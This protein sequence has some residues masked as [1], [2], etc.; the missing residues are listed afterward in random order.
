MNFVYPYFLWAAFA[1]AI[2]ILIHLFNFR[3][4]KKVYFTNVT[5]LRQAQISTRKQNKLKNLLLLL[6][7]CL[8][9]VFLAFLFAQPYVENK[10]NAIVK[11]SGNA[12][13]VFVDNSFSMENAGQSGRLLDDAKAKARQIVEQFNQNDN[14]L[15]LTMDME[16]RHKHFVDKEQF[17]ASLN[18]VDITAATLK[19][20][21]VLNECNAMLQMRNEEKRL[22]VVSDFQTSSFD[23]AAFENDSTAKTFLLPVSANNLN[24][25]FVDS[26]WFASDFLHKGQNIDI[27]A[28]I[29][30]WDEESVEKIPVKLFINEKQ[31]AITSIDLDS[32]RSQNVTMSFV[33]D[34]NIGTTL[35]HGK[36]SI[37]DSPVTFDD[38][39]YFAFNV[40]DKISVCIING[41]QNNKYLE[42]LFASAE[43]VSLTQFTEN[44]I[45]YN[46]LPKFSTII[47]NGV[48]QITSGLTDEMKRFCEDGGTIIIIPNE[49]IDIA[50]YQK[51]MHDLQ[52]ATY[53]RLMTK[54][55]KVSVVN[56]ESSLY[57]G[58]FGS[59]SKG[60]MPI[61]DNMEMPNVS[62][63]FSFERNNV[64]KE[65]IMKFQSNDDFLCLSRKD[66]GKVYIFATELEDK[67]TDFVSQ[68]L[69]VPTLWNMVLFSSSILSPYYFLSE[70]PFIDLTG[71]EQ[72][73]ADVFKVESL[74]KKQSFIAQIAKNTNHIG[75]KLHNQLK[76]AGNYNITTDTAFAAIAFNYDRNESKLEFLTTRQ[77]QSLIKQQKINNIEVFNPSKQ[78]A[79]YFKQSER[80]FPFTPLLIGL[81]LICFGFEAYFLLR[82]RVANVKESKNKDL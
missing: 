78:L 82:K 12:V 60:S 44:N 32:K 35:I 69:F 33:L 41:R 43:E 11:E 66:K 73:T 74:D 61:T 3:R 72:A 45:D 46:T 52:I 9:I 58:V 71:F 21:E 37:L 81:I 6:V 2:P 70:N 7:R 51:A 56:N 30:N 17:I 57:K 40:E 36:V 22:F 48:K 42:R 77:I 39:F 34:N 23:V 80:G 27:T 62:S 8:A 18:D 59:V 55:N 4:F 29:T 24:N 79:T 38:D 15:L 65:S 26:I 13:V 28:R 19:M 47:L 10:Q 5:A 68:S 53:D 54:S 49:Q 25:V 31:V 1:V 67:V 64:S 20:S 50:S 16:G 76:V 75:I 63:Y 14:F